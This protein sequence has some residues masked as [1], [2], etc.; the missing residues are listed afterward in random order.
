MA[1]PQGRLREDASAIGRLDQPGAAVGG[2]R[3]IQSPA[4][5]GRGEGCDTAEGT[6]TARPPGAGPAA[7]LLAPLPQGTGLIIPGPTPGGKRRDGAFPAPV[8]NGQRW[9]SHPSR[10][11]VAGGRWRRLPRRG[12]AVWPRRMR[13]DGVGLLVYWNRHREAEE[14]TGWKSCG[15]SGGRRWPS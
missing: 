14:A 9:R 5:A 13:G 7:V 2:C 1:G 4:D 11:A 15:T 3:P 6:V 12:N 10:L 8:C